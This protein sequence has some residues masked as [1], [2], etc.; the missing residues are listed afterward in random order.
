MSL[1]STTAALSWYQARQLQARCAEETAAICK[2]DSGVSEPHGKGCVYIVR[3]CRK[4]GQNLLY[5][6]MLQHV[7]IITVHAV[8][9]QRQQR[10]CAHVC[11]V[12][13]RGKSLLH[14]M[15]EYDLLKLEESLSH[16]HPCSLCFGAWLT[17]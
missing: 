3:P 13:L 1:L 15:R 10:D 8:D 6:S 2:L 14:R 5:H 17:C 16:R 4:C 9:V 7:A 11:R 12:Q